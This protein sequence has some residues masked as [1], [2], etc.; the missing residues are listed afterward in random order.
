MNAIIEKK[1]IYK[2]LTYI[3]KATDGGWRCGYVEV[4]EEIKGS[5]ILQ[6]LNVHGGIT[7]EDDTLIGFDCHHDCDAVD[8]SIMS[9]D[10]KMMHQKIYGG[11]WKQEGIVR[12]TDYV[13]DQCKYIIDQ[14]L[15]AG[16]LK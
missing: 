1:D 5:P 7:Y 10:Y 11:F 9:E 8:E 2:G 3:I 12:D 16:E 13:E 6:S 15:D 4:P 14:I